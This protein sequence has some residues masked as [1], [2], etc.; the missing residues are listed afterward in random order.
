MYN[1]LVDRLEK[2]HEEVKQTAQKEI[3]KLQ[4]EAEEERTAMNLSDDIDGEVR[5]QLRIREKNVK[6]KQSEVEAKMNE[7]VNVIARAG[8]LV[9]IC[10]M[11]FARRTEVGGERC[12]IVRQ[13]IN[14]SHLGYHKCSCFVF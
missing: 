2:E 1:D 12:Q 8:S 14:L 10:Y 9:W 13:E 11:R 7:E 6:K 5:E 3:S 4:Q